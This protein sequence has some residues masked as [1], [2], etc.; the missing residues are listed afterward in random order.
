[1]AAS[2]ASLRD[3]ELRY[4]HSVT[5]S[6]STVTDTVPSRT[7]ASDELARRRTQ[8]T[9]RVLG[10]VVVG[11]LI[12]AGISYAI[13]TST[14]PD[15]DGSSALQQCSAVNSVGPDCSRSVTWFA[16]DAGSTALNPGFNL[17]ANSLY[18]L[19]NRGASSDCFHKIELRA[20]F[21]RRAIPTA[22]CRNCHQRHADHSR[23]SEP[24]ASHAHL[25]DAG[26][27]RF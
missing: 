4:A 26:L 20:S 5:H 18:K 7:E 27:E 2:E 24:A 12:A 10:F 15:T 9:G 19:S 22:S 21:V 16:D 8:C 17:G 13:Y 25:L 6:A 14:R 3:I 11:A 1:M 23:Q